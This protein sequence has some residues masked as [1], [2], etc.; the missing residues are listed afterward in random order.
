MK[1]NTESRVPI[2]SWTD[3]VPLDPQA[4][5]QLKQ[6]ANMPFIFK[7]L[8]VMPDVHVGLGATV[9]SVVPTKNAIIPAAVGVDIG[10]G[11]MA[12]QLNLTAKDLP[13]NLS[14][15]RA[16][17]ETAI[18]HGRSDGTV[19]D[20]GSWQ[21]KTPD[22]IDVSFKNH[23]LPTLWELIEKHP[24]LRGATPPIIQSRNMLG[25]LGT[26]NHFVELCLDEE[27][28]VW[29]MLHSGS[30][31][32][33]NRIGTYFISKAK[34]EMERWHIE[35]PNK[36]LAYLPEG[37]ELFDDYW[38]ALTWAQGYARLNRQF[39]FEAARRAASAAFKRPILNYTPVV[40]C[41]HNYATRENH[42]GQNIIITRKGAVCARP[43]MLGIIPG[44]MG[45]KSFIVRGKG[46]PESFNS[47]SHGAG[48]VMSRKEAKRS[49]SL[50]DHIKDTEGVECRKDAEVIDESP[51][52]YK[53]VEDVM[54]SQEE[55][56]EIV[57]T[58]K[59]IVCVKG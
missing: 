32:I 10:C 22:Y 46:N 2:K 39:M 24:K 5:E 15:V 37:T 48:R 59:G 44:S 35:L 45:A 41:H 16:M 7:H 43:N 40:N 52:A 21:G 57:H 42:F 11:M 13:D 17:I 9:G 54:K 53:N 28:N 19:N 23:L 18:P 33:G 34:E 49:I 3:Y 6:T 14:G 51:R 29:L 12:A 56:V 4:L 30:R 1:V 20:V 27:Q 31:G 8:A 25:T 58:L 38:K 36:D 47:C 50:E 26:G 55:L